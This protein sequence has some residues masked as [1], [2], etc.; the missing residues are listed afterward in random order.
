MMRLRHVL[1][2]IFC[3]LCGVAHGA[4]EISPQN[5]IVENVALIMS[6][7]GDYAYPLAKISNPNSNVGAECATY[8][9]YLIAEDDSIIG[10]DENCTSLLPQEIAYVGGQIDLNGK[11]VK[12]MKL[13]MKPVR[14]QKVI[15]GASPKVTVTNVSAAKSFMGYK[16]TGMANN[17]SS[18]NLDTNR[19]I[20]IFYDKAGEVIDYQTAFVD[21]PPNDQQPFE[22]L[23]LAQIQQE[24]A[25]LEGFI[26]PSLV[27]QKGVFTD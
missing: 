5:P 7:S 25:R 27:M 26:S 2:I 4:D 14:W 16:A 22:T 6:A 12:E 17:E 1:G 24:P 9:I 3:L 13:K 21:L 20:I 19:V 8:S 23:G 15:E 18:M 11:A 10:V